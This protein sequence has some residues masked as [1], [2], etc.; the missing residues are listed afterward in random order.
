MMGLKVNP[1]EIRI[2]VQR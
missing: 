2:G 1:M